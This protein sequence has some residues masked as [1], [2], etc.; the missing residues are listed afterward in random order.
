MILNNQF[1]EN[2]VTDINEVLSICHTIRGDDKHFELIAREDKDPYLFLREH[3]KTID[4][5]VELIHSLT[6]NDYNDG[7]LE[8][9]NSK[10]KRAL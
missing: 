9:D 2:E 5:V 3:N 6:I 10:R 7:P 4:D 1:D 8:D